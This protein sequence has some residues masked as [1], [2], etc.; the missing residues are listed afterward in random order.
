MAKPNRNTVS[1]QLTLSPLAAG[2]LAALEDLGVGGS[3]GA[4]VERLLE[5][6]VESATWTIAAAAVLRQRA[7]GGTPEELAREARRVVYALLTGA[8]YLQTLREV[9]RPAPGKLRADLKVVLKSSASRF[10]LVYGADGETPREVELCAACAA[11]G[12]VACA[13]CVDLV[14]GAAEPE[15]EAARR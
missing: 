2:A 14:N 9:T 7:A 5:E 3:A 12:M 6:R 15:P 4:V 11:A 13:S 10:A 8:D 1:K